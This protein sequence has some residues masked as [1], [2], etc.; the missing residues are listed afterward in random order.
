[1][2]VP[3]QCLVDLVYDSHSTFYFY[4]FPHI[5]ARLSHIL[6]SMTMFPRCSRPPP[7]VNYGSSLRLVYDSDSTFYLLPS[8]HFRT[9]MQGYLTFWPQW[10][11]SRPPPYVN[12]GSSLCLVYDSD[13]TF[14]FPPIPAHICKL[15]LHE[16]QRRC[17]RQRQYG[18]AEY[19]FNTIGEVHQYSTFCLLPIPACI[20]YTVYAQDELIARLSHVNVNY[21]MVRF[22]APTPDVNYGSSLLK[23]SSW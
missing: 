2:E 3:W 19:T 18:D 13:P 22:L 10:R 14:Y 16:S 12:Y 17:S 20:H 6:T 15:Y 7:Y 8:T 11:C 4:P 9:Y 23:T 5:Y 1:M 21:V